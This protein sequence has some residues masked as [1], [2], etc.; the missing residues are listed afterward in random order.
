MKK[1]GPFLWGGD[2]IFT[3]RS[4]TERSTT[5]PA[6]GIL[7][8]LCLQYRSKAF[9]IEKMQYLHA[10]LEDQNQRKNHNENFIIP[11]HNF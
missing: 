2:Q 6:C 3:Q 7:A 5:N 8:L 11:F 1:N 9:C 10:Y 4:V